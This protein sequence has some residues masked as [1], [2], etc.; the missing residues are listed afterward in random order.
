MT[1]ACNDDDWTRWVQHTGDGCPL[2][3]GIVVQEVVERAPDVDHS[4]Y[5]QFAT[6]EGI[7]GEGD[8]RW[9]WSNRGTETEKGLLW[10]VVRYR[11]ARYRAAAVL[12][13]AFSK[14]RQETST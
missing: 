13:A 8:V 3:P 10:R 12:I 2:P 11:V 1:D 5:D 14:V 7:T 9:D 6:R 4:K